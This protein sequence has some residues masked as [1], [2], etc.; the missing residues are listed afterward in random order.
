VHLETKVLY[1]A[2]SLGGHRHA[3]DDLE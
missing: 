2:N 3:I 1:G